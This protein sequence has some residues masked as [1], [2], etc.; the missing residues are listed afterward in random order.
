MLAC[1]KFIPTFALANS[2]YYLFYLFLPG[3]YFHEEK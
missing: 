1:V 2:K 3:K